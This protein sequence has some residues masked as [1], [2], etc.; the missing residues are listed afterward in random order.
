MFFMLPDQMLCV[1]FA[2]SYRAG[3]SFNHS[4]TRIEGE[5]I[6]Q[7]SHFRSL[8]RMSRIALLVSPIPSTVGL[9]NRPY[10]P[11]KQ[12]HPESGN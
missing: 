12:S 7:K 1:W 10:R 6:P 8:E 2:F 9:P 4:L 11:S 5:H 3:N